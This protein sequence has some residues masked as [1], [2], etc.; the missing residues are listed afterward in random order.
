[1]A[2]QKRIDPTSMLAVGFSCPA[3]TEQF[4]EVKITGDHTVGPLTDPGDASRLGSVAALDLDGL[5]CTVE[6]HFR[7]QFERTAGEDVAVG[8]FVYGADNEVFQYTPGSK[9]VIAGT[10]AGDFTITTDGNDKLKAKVGPNGASE[11]VTLTAGTRTAAQVAVDINSQATKFKAEVTDDDKVMLICLQIGASMEIEA[12]TYD[13]Y[14]A[15]GLT[16]AAVDGSYP[17]H[18]GIDG[19]IIRSGST[20]ASVVVLEK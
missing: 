19:I 10:V 2:V 20:G 5:G 14:S 9:A 6:C 11:T 15:L 18:D 7:Q 3:G 4:D 13:C 17:S 16:A 12:V 8:P 1:M